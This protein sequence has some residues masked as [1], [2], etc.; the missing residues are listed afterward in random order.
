M[1]V[2]IK[3][4]LLDHYLSSHLYF[5]L[6]LCMYLCSFRYRSLCIFKLYCM[7][8]HLNWMYITWGKVCYDVTFIC[9]C[10][11]SPSQS[12]PNRM[13]HFHNQPSNSIDLNPS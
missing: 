1:T 4:M 5:D 6:P 12:I 2:T 10:V 9:Y 8:L 7:Q 11:P 3:Y 13:R